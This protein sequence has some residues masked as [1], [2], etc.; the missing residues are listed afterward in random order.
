MLIPV[1]VCIFHI[2]SILTEMISGGNSLGVND[3]D[4]RFAMTVLRDAKQLEWRRGELRK[5][6]MAVKGVFMYRI[7]EAWKELEEY[8][9]GGNA[10]VTNGTSN[11]LKKKRAKEVVDPLF[12]KKEWNQFDSGFSL[13]G[14]GSF[15]GGK[16]QTRKKRKETDEFLESKKWNDIDSSFRI[17]YFLKTMEKLCLVLVCSLV[18]VIVI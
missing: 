16:V 7:S 3:E 13:W 18:M 12:K 14:R 17:I 11:Q 1:N 8:E 15:D 5:R 2:H 4:A 6:E 9:E 10:G